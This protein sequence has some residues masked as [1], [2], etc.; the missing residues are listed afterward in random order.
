MNTSDT[1][2]I[3]FSVPQGSQAGP[4]LYCL[5]ASTIITV[6]PKDIG[7]NAFAD[8]HTLIN[9]F[10]PDYFGIGELNCLNEIESCCKKIKNW[11]DQ[12]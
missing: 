10:T 1:K 4:D 2:T 5:Y 9:N 6:I 3:N 8:D 7:L 12:N 11:M